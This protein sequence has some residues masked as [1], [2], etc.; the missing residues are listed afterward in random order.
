VSGDDRLLYSLRRAAKRLG[1]RPATLGAARRSGALTVVPWLGGWRIPKGEV[2]RLAREGLTPAARKP[3]RRAPSPP[4]ST[5]DDI[6]SI[7]VD[8]P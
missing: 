6:R 3:R 8:G 7:P 5:P 2:E 4:T 1:V